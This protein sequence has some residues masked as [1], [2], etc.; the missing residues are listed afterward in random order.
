MMV[1]LLC[2]LFCYL[3][4]LITLATPKRVEYNFNV[5]YI[6]NTNP[7]GRYERQVIGINGQFP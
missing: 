1:F 7:D 6:L 3:A 2:T 5:G 4:C